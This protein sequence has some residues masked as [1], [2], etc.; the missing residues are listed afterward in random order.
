MSKLPEDLS[1]V[2]VCEQEAMEILG[3]GRTTLYRLVKEGRIEKRKYLHRSVYTRKSLSEF[4]QSWWDSTESARRVIKRRKRHRRNG[5]RMP[6]AE[7][8]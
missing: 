2:V 6:N 5:S 4:K 8:G 1:K 3:C 7:R